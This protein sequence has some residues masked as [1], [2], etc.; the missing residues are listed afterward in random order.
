FA[1]NPVPGIRP[2]FVA[3]SAAQ[4]RI[5]AAFILG[6]FTGAL[7]VAK[8]E[9]NIAS[10][11]AYSELI[12][13]VWADAVA[14]RHDGADARAFWLDKPAAVFETDKVRRALSVMRIEAA[15]GHWQTVIS[16]APA[17]ERTLAALH[18][19]NPAQVRE[20]Q[21][22]PVLALAKARL[23]DIGEAQALIAA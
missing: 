10:S 21:F 19:A 9:P 8:S 20:V 14:Q 23:G 2:S 11:I 22:R 12:M 18:A 16:T 1:R 4:N 6:D 3:R 17:V 15:L 5:Q 13:G 7:A